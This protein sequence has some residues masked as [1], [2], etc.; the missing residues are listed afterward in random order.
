MSASAVYVN[1]GRTRT[2]YYTMLEIVKGLGF[3]V[4]EAGWQMFRLKSTFENTLKEKAIVVA[5]DEVDAIIYKER[6][7]IIYYLNRQ[8]KTSATR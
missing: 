8:P 1:A 5:I 4:P 6:E 7:P 3:D 2:P